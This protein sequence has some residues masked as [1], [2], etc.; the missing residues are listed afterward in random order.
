M[1]IGLLSYRSRHIRGLSAVPATAD[2]TT[3]PG[4]STQISDTGA[5][6]SAGPPGGSEET[7]DS[8]NA[9]QRVVCYY[10]PTV[11]PECRACRTESTLIVV[12]CCFRS[13]FVWAFAFLA[14]ALVLWPTGRRRRSPYA[15][16]PRAECAGATRAE[17]RGGWLH[18]VVSHES[19]LHTYNK[20]YIM[21]S[22]LRAC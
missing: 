11:P 3:A 1:V 7:R 8:D 6:L 16:S 21:S 22:R 4:H 20:R 15:P 19:K 2:P 17:V 14:C 18:T 9:Q 13:R 10:T 5:S 12:T